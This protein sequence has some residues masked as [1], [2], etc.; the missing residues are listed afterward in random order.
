MQPLQSSS[1]GKPENKLKCCTHIQKAP[2]NPQLQALGAFVFN[3]LHHG[4]GF[5]LLRGR[6]E[7][8]PGRLHITKDQRYDQP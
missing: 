5:W 1:A 4:F 6:T 3:S 7:Q 2:T 8:H